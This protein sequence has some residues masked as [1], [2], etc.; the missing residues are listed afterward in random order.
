MRCDKMDQTKADGCKLFV[1]QKKPNGQWNE[2]KELPSNI[3]TGN[4]KTPRIM[5]DSE[6]LIFSSNKISPT[7]GG[8][9]LFVSKLKDGNWSDPRPLEFANTEIDDQ[10]VS[11]AALGRYLLKDAPG[12]RKNRELVEFLIPNELRPKGMMKVEG[13]VTDENNAPVPAYITITDLASRARVYS[14]RPASDG[15]YFV[16]LREG[17]TY[18]L[19]FD[20]EQSKIGFF[21]KLFDLT[22]DKIPQREKLNAVLKQPTAGTEFSLDMVQFKPNT[23]D[24]EP[25]S[26][27]EL[28]RFVRMAKANPELSFEIQVMLNGYHEDSIQSSPDLTELTMDSIQV[29]VDDIDTLGQV[30]K[31]DTIIV[32]SRYHNNRTQPQALAIVEYLTR[33]GVGNQNLIVFTNAIPA[34]LPE[35]KKLTVKI[36]ARP[37]K[38][39]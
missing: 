1:A 21:A 31:R 16:Y 25:S 4:S 38:T 18:E 32:K 22:T 20:P 2:P 34:V 8:M 29:Q 11:V 5:A 17:S 30:F 19:S 24:L 13:K 12:P 27:P 3:N 33:L 28:K 36:V 6:T 14:G 15:S 26:E 35:N 9:D 39:Q 37:K 23:S 7:K 10:F